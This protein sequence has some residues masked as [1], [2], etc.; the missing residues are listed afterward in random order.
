MNKQPTKLHNKKI[1]ASVAFGF[2]LLLL[3][4]AFVAYFTSLRDPISTFIK[5]LYPAGSAGGRF[6]SIQARDDAQRV[7]RAFDEKAG[8]DAGMNLLVEIS[9]KQ[10]LLSSLGVIVTPQDLE[11][12]LAFMKDGSKA[13][14]EDLLGKYFGNDEQVF[15]DLVL[16]PRVY[17]ALLAIQYNSDFKLNASSYSKAKGILALAKTGSDF[18][19]LAASSDDEVTG[20]LGGDLGFVST[21]QILPELTEKLG[22]LT[23]GKVHD[24]I[25]VS[26]VGYHIVMLAEVSEQDGQK[27]YH[28]KHVLIQT[29]GF[30]QWLAP[31]LNKISTW[32]IK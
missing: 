21:S 29:S 12:E 27:L 30:D 7:A 25:L 32:R 28:L 11:A 10:Q 1:Y 14:Y 19:T 16:V 5:G 2:V 6:I 4:T 13:Q 9:K 20:Q 17:D 26:R 24:E 22:D 31:Q 18:A 3:L 23:A 8:S 15:T